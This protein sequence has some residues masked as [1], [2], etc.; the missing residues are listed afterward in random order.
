MS[1]IGTW[2]YLDSSL[3]LPNPHVHGSGAAVAVGSIVCTA[4]GRRVREFPTHQIVVERDAL[5][6]VSL[7]ESCNV[8]GPQSWARGEVSNLNIVDVQPHHI[9]VVEAAGGSAI[10]LEREAL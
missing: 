1:G 6:E 2:A 5:E 8:I 3:P 4:T 9:T 10:T 7:R